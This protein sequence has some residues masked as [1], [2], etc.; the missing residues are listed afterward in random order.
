MDKFAPIIAV[1]NDWGT[2]SDIFDDLGAVTLDVEDAHEVR[3]ALKN[4]DAVVFTGG[5]DI[6]PS[7]YGIEEGEKHPQVYGLST[8]RDEAEFLG[9]RM[10]RKMRLPVLGICRGHQLINVGHGGTPHQHLQDGL[11]KDQLHNHEGGDH[12]VK[13]RKQSRIGRR[14]SKVGILKNVTSLHH[15]AVD[16]LGDGLVP[17]GWATDGTVEMIETAPG[18]KPYMLGTQFHPEMDIRYIG[19]EA[20]AIF[21]F[22]YELASQHCVSVGGNKGRLAEVDDLVTWNKYKTRRWSSATATTTTPSASIQKYE[23]DVKSYYV[24]HGSE[25]TRW[26]DVEETDDEEAYLSWS[27]RMANARKAGGL[28]T[29][30]DADR[31]CCL[32]EGCRSPYDCLE[33]DDCAADVIS[34]LGGIQ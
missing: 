22:I 3:R 12:A 11:N 19:Y 20:E 31:M 28:G 24:D 17:V 9:F 15:Q 10:A 5:G 33:F 29:V 4:A 21:E 25:D 8:S 7:R 27:T 16:R 30:Q 26:S 2:V 23:A 32:T 34:N 1:F 14:M 13:M 6:D 18:V